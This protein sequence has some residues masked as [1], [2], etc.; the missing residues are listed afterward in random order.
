MTVR[1][2]MEQWMR[3]G[4]GRSTWNI[5]RSA[6]PVGISRPGA[7]GCVVCTIVAA[8][9]P[10]RARRFARNNTFVMRAPTGPG[11]LAPMPKLPP[12]AARRAV[13]GEHVVGSDAPHHAGAWPLHQ[14]YKPRRIRLHF[15]QRAAVGDAPTAGARRVEQDRI[16]P[17]LRARMPPSGLNTFDASP[18]A[19]VA[20]GGRAASP[21]AA[22]VSAHAAAAAVRRLTGSPP[23]SA[24][25]S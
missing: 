3:R 4:E 7:S 10:V 24:S 14:R 2:W 9:S 20:A 23:A 17:I 18:M 21:A 6:T 12:D 15:P 13:R 19:V 8:R 22:S 16:Q 11:P 1:W 5:Q 25:P